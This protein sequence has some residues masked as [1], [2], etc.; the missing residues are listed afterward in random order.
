MISKFNF[1]TILIIFISTIQAAKEGHKRQMH[2]FSNNEELV[3][4][5]LENLKNIL[6]LSDCR[7]FP[8]VLKFTPITIPKAFLPDQEKIISFLEKPIIISDP[9]PKK[10]AIQR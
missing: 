6:Q 7:S 10:Y 9:R 1:T 2:L 5:V 8:N 3:E 4:Q